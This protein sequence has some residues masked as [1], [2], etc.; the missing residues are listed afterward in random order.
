MSNKRNRQ[1]LPPR[2]VLFAEASPLVTRVIPSLAKEIGLNESILLLQLAWWVAHA[3]DDNFRD[4][5]WWTYQSV[6]DMQDKAFCYWS[7]MTINRTVKRLITKKLVIE[8]NYNSADYDKTRWFA[9][10]PDE[11]RKLKSIRLEWSDLY[12][13][14]TPLYQGDTPSGTNPYQNDTTIP[15]IPTETPTKE[16]APPVSA[17]VM[18]PLKDAIVLAMGWSWTTM[19]KSEKGSVQSAAKE[20]AEASIAPDTVKLLKAECDMRG[21]KGYTAL[22]LCKVVSDVLKRQSPATPAPVTSNGAHAHQPA[23]LQPFE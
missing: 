18:N 4:G 13:N 21:W 5:K 22:A 11:L 15:E 10:N 7:L 23:H 6:R 14:D 3:S 2:P 17:S 16:K 8:G 20:L 1:N 12:Q 19:T 9:L